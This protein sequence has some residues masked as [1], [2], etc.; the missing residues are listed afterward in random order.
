MT[1][2]VDEIVLRALAKERERRQQSA[3]EMKSEVKHASEV[4]AVREARKRETGEEPKGE[5]LLGARCHFSTPDRL[6]SPKGRMSAPFSGQGEARLFENCLSLVENDRRLNI[7]LKSIRDVSVGHFEWWSQKGVK[8][9]FVSLT[10]D[11]NGVGHTI[12]LT[13]REQWVEPLADTARLTAQWAEE[14]RKAVTAK[15]EKELGVT[16]EKNVSVTN[17]PYW[18]LNAL[19]AAILF[20]PLAGFMGAEI[21]KSGEAHRELGPILLGFGMTLT[22]LGAA[23]AAVLAAIAFAHTRRAIGM[24]NLQAL[25]ERHPRKEPSHS[26]P[27]AD[28]GTEGTRVIRKWS[29]AVIIG[30]VCNGLALVPAA[31]LMVFVVM[32]APDPSWNPAVAELVV[33]ISAVVVWGL[34]AL[35]GNILGAV[36]VRNIDA[37]RGRLKSREL[38]SR[39]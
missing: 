23:L 14:I 22:S 39:S 26:T 2:S 3:E 5:A 1:D 29:K 11:V 15:T 37:S 6:R 13:L 36:G 27:N 25:T 12:T 19:I 4:G 17:A 7:P 8:I 9:P 16:S 20:V 33:T 10:Q 35:A 30:A 21:V 18:I 32:M 28:V 24:G 34:L 31:L 38:A